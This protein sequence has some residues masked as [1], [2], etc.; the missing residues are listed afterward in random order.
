[1]KKFISIVIILN[2]LFILNTYGQTLASVIDESIQ[3][4][5]QGNFNISGDSFNPYNTSLYFDFSILD[6]KD[7]KKVLAGPIEGSINSFAHRMYMVLDSANL[8]LPNGVSQ[9]KY[10]LRTSPATTF[11]VESSVGTSSNKMTVES[12]ASLLSPSVAGYLRFN[13]VS[14]AGTTVKTLALI[15]NLPAV[16]IATKTVGNL[17]INDYYIQ[18]MDPSIPGKVFQLRFQQIYCSSKLAQATET[19]GCKF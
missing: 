2:T 3:H 15:A 4:L 12:H 14:S 8:S 17:T 9:K 1:M 19:S 10:Y 11:M 7:E 5:R 16:K 13:I 18:G 6:A